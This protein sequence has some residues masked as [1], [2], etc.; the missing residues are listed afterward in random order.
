MDIVPTTITFTDA[1]G[2]HKDI[3]KTSGGMVPYDVCRNSYV[4]TDGTKGYTR[5]LDSGF[6]SIMQWPDGTLAI[7]YNG[8]ELRG[9]PATVRPTKGE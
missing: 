9:F 1:K 5:A 6:L 2:N 3:R 4:K 8:Q 7:K